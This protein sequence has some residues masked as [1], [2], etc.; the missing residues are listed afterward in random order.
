M[1]HH[2]YQISRLVETD[3]P[4]ICSW[5][6]NAEELQ[7]ISTNFGSQLTPE[8]LRQ[9]ADD[10]V[11]TFVLRDR[12]TPV[13][14]ATMSTKEWP[15]PPDT[16]EGCH[17]IIDPSRR[18]RSAAT[19]LINEMAQSALTHYRTF[20]GRVVPSNVTSQHFLTKLGWFEITNRYP[21]TSHSSFSW[22]QAPTVR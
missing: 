13:G 8:I 21:W 14:F 6:P 4:R 10:A 22:F 12:G 19:F 16:V 3:V 5:V 2:D 20:V 18:R 9:W 17:L 15:L 11:R 1:S 7:R